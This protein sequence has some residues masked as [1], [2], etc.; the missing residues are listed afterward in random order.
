[1]KDKLVAVTGGGGF[2]GHHLVSQLVERGARVRV[3]NQSGL[4][5]EVKGAE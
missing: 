5:S 1:M 2:I 3:F 4:H